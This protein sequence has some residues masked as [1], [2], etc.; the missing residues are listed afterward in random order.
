MKRN[1]TFIIATFLVLFAGINLPFISTCAKSNQVGYEVEGG[2]LWFDITTG[3]IT[4][5]QET[6]TSAVIPETIEGVTVQSI[7]EWA[8]YNH[9]GL[10]SVTLPDTVTIIKKGAFY[11]CSS[12]ESITIPKGVTTIEKN[13]FKYCSSLVLV[14]YAGDKNAISMEDVFPDWMAIGGDFSESYKSGKYYKKLMKVKLTDNIRNNIINVAKS[15]YG[16][17][18]GSSNNNLGGNSKS[19]KNYTEYGYYYRDNPV[20]W[21]GDFAEWCVEVAGLPRSV[22]E[23]GY[24]NKTTWKKMKYAGKGG[25]KTLKKGDI[26]RVTKTTGGGHMFLVEKVKKKGKYVYITFRDGGHN[27]QVYADTVKI[28]AKT[29]KATG[30]YSHWKMQYVVSPDYSKLVFHTVTFDAN[31]GTVSYSSR[32]IAEGAMYSVMPTPTKSGST[33]VGWYTDPAAGVRVKPYMTFG[34][35]TD[36][37]LYARWE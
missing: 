17:H 15:Q 1:A 30:T 14:N 19:D 18:E 24:Q 10:T 29:G 13:A 31:G 5:A 33:F 3:E 9:E 36:Q 8:F 16:Y 20:L 34:K 7:G 37:T 26:C 21:C 27:N 22:L 2:K 12:L 4:W 32:K 28:N 11:G 6:V 35:K 25:K 23:D